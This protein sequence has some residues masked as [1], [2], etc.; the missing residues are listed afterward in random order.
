MTRK[1][2]EGE[3]GEESRL[4]EEGESVWTERGSASAS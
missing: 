4:E 1:K 3:E 2:E